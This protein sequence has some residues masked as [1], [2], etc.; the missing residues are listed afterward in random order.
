[1]PRASPFDPPKLLDTLMTRDQALAA[2][3]YFRKPELP[4]PAERVQVTRPALPE[5][6]VKQV[7]A[8]EGVTTNH[9]PMRNARP[10]PGAVGP[11]TG[12]GVDEHG[13]T[14]VEC[15]RC[16]EPTRLFG[17]E[18]IKVGRF[19]K[20]CSKCFKAPN[21]CGCDREYPT[22]WLLSTRRVIGCD[23]CVAEYNTGV[24]SG[25]RDFFLRLGDS[26]GGGAKTNAVAQPTPS[27]NFS[28]LRAKYGI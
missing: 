25:D 14:T 10:A 18:R 5:P 17:A 3:R 16:A 23:A 13:N 11:Q 2:S 22:R 9:S 19:F 4:P 26:A 15:G 1:M 8:P 27:V 21:Q 7:I 20:A 24:I 12:Y 28:A 6:I